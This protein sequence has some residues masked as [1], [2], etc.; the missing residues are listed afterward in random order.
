MKYIRGNTPKAI[1]LENITIIMLPLVHF[2]II[3]N[4]FVAFLACAR[5]IDCHNVTFIAEKMAGMVN[6]E[7]VG[8][9]ISM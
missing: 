2:I 6:S 9:A 4:F 5:N 7:I 8:V 1:L 3:T